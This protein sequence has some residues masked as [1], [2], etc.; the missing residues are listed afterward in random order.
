MATQKLT[1]SVTEG[2]ARGKADYV[3]WDAEL[4]GSVS[5]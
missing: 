1:K 4:P 5:A 2:L 3:V